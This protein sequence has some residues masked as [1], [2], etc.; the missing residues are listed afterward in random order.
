MFLVFV[1]FIYFSGGDGVFISFL[2]IV[3]L[4][5]LGFGLG[6]GLVFLEF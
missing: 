5:V 1:E 2:L 4:I 3:Y 6:S